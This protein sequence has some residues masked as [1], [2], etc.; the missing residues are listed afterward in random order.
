MIATIKWLDDPEVFRVSQMAAHSDHISYASKEEAQEGNSS[1]YQ[2]LNGQWWFSYAKNPAMRPVNF[3]EAGFDYSGFDKITVPSH[4]ELA[5][6][7]K[8]H[9]TN[10]AY[11]WEGREFRRP[12]YTVSENNTG[13]GMFSEAG[14]NP[15]GSY[16]TTFK[17]DAGLK[18]KSVSIRFD[19]VEQAMYIW[20]NSHFVGYAEDSFTPSEFDLTPYLQ[21]ENTLAV[22]VYKQCSASYYEDQDF[23]RFFGIFRDVTL[24]ARGKNH[25][26]DMWIQP[27]L[28]E[29]NVTGSLEFDFTF[30]NISPES[31]LHINITDNTGKLIH[32]V[33]EKVEE[34]VTISENIIGA[35]QPWSNKTPILYNFELSTFDSAGNCTQYTSY[36]FGFR[37]I[38]IKDKLI[39]LNGE[40]L[41]LNG[42]N[43]HEWHPNKGRA[44]TQ[45]E[46]LMDIDIIKRNNINAVRTSHYPC[47][48]PWYY[49]CDGAG[50]YVMAESNLE[51]HGTWHRMA[52]AVEPSYN[53]P[54]AVKQWLEVLIDR[55]RTN[56]MTFRNHTS[57]LFW[58]LGNES[59]ADENLRLM[60]HYFKENDPDRL[61][62]Y[63]GNDWNPEFEDKMSDVKSRM[64]APPAEIEEYLKNNP[65]RPFI[66][67]EYMHDM[68]N[69]M[70]GLK[71]YMDLIDKYDMY[72]GAFIWDFIDQALYVKDE[73]TGREV[74]R[75]GGDFD[76]RPSDYEFS[77]NGIIFANREEKPAM[78]EVKY[79]YGKY[80]K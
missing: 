16:M 24:V 61:V 38:E 5:G 23:F 37:R 41:I 56:F 57:I 65:Q 52:N 68:G 6:Y 34:K 22:E 27:R 59:Y 33:V 79:Y 15:V 75:Y 50:L 31:T 21:E 35:V 43:R 40:R 67:C 4:I 17:L 25:L 62:H 64:Y 49:L 69:S 76:D 2:L 26:A 53:V 44:I 66:H 10:I 47:Q 46:N 14:Y 29:D 19:G 60:N 54:G 28:L 58:S 11:P 36:P 7:D 13:E 74:L 80:S 63:E 48:I 18:D 51:S 55:A 39:L 42:V 71:S 70:G 73:V 77:G 45:E 3:Y 9:Y 30:E 72:Q 12:A 8:I 20:L 1:L 78:Q 32:H